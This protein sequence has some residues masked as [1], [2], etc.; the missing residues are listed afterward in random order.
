VVKEER[1]VIEAPPANGSVKETA[2]LASLDSSGPL[3]CRYA[4]D[5][6]NGAIPLD[7]CFSKGGSQACPLCGTRIPVEAG[8]AWRVE[9]EIVHERINT[10][11]YE[12]EVIE[13]R[14]YLLGNRFIVKCHREKAGFA[15]VLCYRY[16]DRDTICESI[17]GLVKHVWAKHDVAE[18]ESDPDIKEVG[19]REEIVR[20]DH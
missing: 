2:A 8:R 3:F 20:K 5:M 17:G 19:T 13:E 10:P 14:T 9:K 15:C 11:T 7:E 18:Y 6:Q 16:R 1:T 12:D 4:V